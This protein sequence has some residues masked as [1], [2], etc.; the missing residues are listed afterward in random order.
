MLEDKPMRKN[1]ALYSILRLKELPIIIFVIVVFCF[2]SFATENFFKINNLET[3]LVQMTINGIV[4][5][6]MTM[7]IMIGGMDLSVGSV[8]VVCGVL[9]GMMDNAGMNIFVIILITILIGAIAGLINGLLITKLHIIDIIVTL[10]T[11][12]IYRGLAVLITGADWITNF[13]P[14]YLKLGSPNNGILSIPTIV[15]LAI[16]VIFSVVLK[17]TPYGRSLYAIGGNR[18]AAKLMGMNVEKNHVFVYVINGCLFAIAGIFYAS[19]YGNIQAGTAAKNIQFLTMGSVLIGGANIFGGSGTIL[20][21][22]FGILLMGLMKNGLIL[23][24]ASEYWLDFITGA[25]ILLAL[26]MN[27]LR[28]T[29][30][31]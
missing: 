20:G 5:V 22:F 24:S 18:T 30:R 2:F 1:K 3:I 29:K 16:V 25:I 14:T 31:K 13:S 21:T 26:I 23:F 6:G 9:S 15:F 27:L 19:M 8:L 11:M 4:A 28:V 17:K 7:V 10:A 12:N